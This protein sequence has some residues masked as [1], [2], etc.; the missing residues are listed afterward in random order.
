MKTNTEKD[1]EYIASKRSLIHKK[2]AE[3][4]RIVALNSMHN[5]S[6]V[7]YYIEM[8]MGNAMSG[9]GINVYLGDQLVES[10]DCFGIGWPFENMIFFHKD[11]FDIDV[12][13]KLIEL[14]TIRKIAK[15]YYDL[16][17]K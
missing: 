8:S 7:K 2:V 16:N 5:T 11:R 10:A 3:I 6:T 14:E 4:S 1:A 15:K 9:L 17:N 12:N 13:R